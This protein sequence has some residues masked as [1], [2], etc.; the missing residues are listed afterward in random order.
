MKY[1]S[2]IWKTRILKVT[3]SL[4]ELET[5]FKKPKDRELKVREIENR[6]E[7]KKLFL[8]II[9]VSIEDAK[10]TSYGLYD[11][12]T[13]HISKTIKIRSVM[14]KTKLWVFLK[15][16]QTRIIVNQHE[17]KPR[18]PTKAKKTNNKK[19]SKDNKIE[20]IRN[21]FRLAK[22]EAIKGKRIRDIKNLYKPEKDT[23]YKPVRV[24]NCYSN[25]YIEYASN[26]DRNKT[27]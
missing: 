18:K 4:L 7:V 22:K 6:K 20:N 19:Q 8:K 3:D 1:L 12:L 10:N 9:N 14:F 16:T 23:Y 24:N 27:A 13:N 26:G 17:K 2:N 21:L 25:N 11:W 5:N 15:H